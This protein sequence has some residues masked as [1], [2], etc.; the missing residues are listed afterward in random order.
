[1]WLTLDIG[2]SAVK[3][4]LFDGAALRHVFHVDV[5]AVE[6]NPDAAAEAWR[7]ALVRELAEHGT[8][9]AVERTGMASVVPDLLA[10]AASALRALTGY[11]PAVVHPAMRLPFALAYATPQTLGADRLAAAAAAWLRYGPPGYGD[12]SPRHNAPRPVVAVDAGTA[13]TYEVIGVEGTYRGGAIAPG[14]VLMQQALRRG[15]AQL[16]TV[17]LA[18]PDD[19][20]GTSTQA[21]MQSGIMGSFVDGVRG[22]MERLTACLDSDGQPAPVVVVTGGWGRLLGQH[23]DAVDHVEPHLVLHGIRA[24]MAMNA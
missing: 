8:A 3:G 6:R 21:A 9:Q 16:P 2:N 12:A 14:P 18:F 5:R 15:T 10:S 24:L 17:P 23:L 11:P 13:V 19:P 22:M 7:Q 1:M 4:A 20:I